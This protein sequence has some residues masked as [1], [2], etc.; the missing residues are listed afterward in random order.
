MM[1]ELNIQN[2]LDNVG[3]N[4]I[5]IDARSP[6]EFKQSHIKNAIN[7]YV[8]DNDERARVGSIYKKSPFDAK[9]LGASLIS[10]NVSKHLQGYLSNITPK[11]KIFIYCSRGGQ[12]SGSFGV[13]L[14]AIGFRVYKLK[15]GY[16]AYRNYILN[17]LDTF[18]Y[19]KFIVLD[20]YTGSGKSEIIR[21]F[22]NSIDLESLANHCGSSF[23]NISGEQPSAKQFQNSIYNELK[24][25]KKH[26]VTLIEG[27]SKKIGKLQIPCKLYRTMLKAPRIWIETPLEHRVQRIVK[28]YR[29]IDK[30]FFEKAIKKITPYIK[31]EYLEEAKKAFYEND[32]QRCAAILLEKYYDKVYKKRD[33]YVLSIKFDNIEKVLKEIKEFILTRTSL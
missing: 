24:R 31:K 4:S 7:L 17:Y 1:E 13:I 2:F 15:G 21:H 30:D 26:D 11:T 3:Q 8:L 22:E 23:G 28:E 12:R 19:D 20:G 32:F 14:S 29:S 18:S 27:E 33:N 9:M 6:A 10:A 16:K 25:V 5:L